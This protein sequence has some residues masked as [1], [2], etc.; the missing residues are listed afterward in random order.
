MGG[1]GGSSTGGAG[2]SYYHNGDGYG[3]AGGT[4]SAGG[5]SLGGGGGGAGYSS[6]PGAGGAAVGGIFNSGTLHLVGGA[7]SGNIAVGGGG[8]GGYFSTFGG[9]GGAAVGG[10]LNTGVLTLDNAS[11][12]GNAA[13]GGA[14]G[15]GQFGLGAAG[16]ATSNL[17]GAAT[18][19]NQPHTGSV[20]LSGA[21]TQGQTLTAA[22]TLADGNGLGTIG[23]Q[24]KSDGANI[25]GAVSSTL[26]LAQAQ[27]GHLITVTG[28]Y[29]DGAGFA[30]SATSA[31]TSAVANVNDAPTGAVTITG[32]ATQGQT[33]TAANTLADADGLGTIGYQ[34][35]ADG[36]NISGATGSTLAL[37]QAQVGHVITV[38]AGYTDG[39]G[40]AESVT[41]SGTSAVANVNDAPTG[42]VTIAG[43]A[44]QGQVL[45]ASNTL[46]DADGL[47]T[48]GYQWKAD[49]ANI[50]GATGSTLTLAQAQ[51]GHMITVA[52]SYVDSL[53]TAESVASSGTTAVANVNDA[54]TG[55]VSIAGTATQGQV[56]TASNTL[57]DADG[58]G[59]IGYQWKAD[60][61]DISGATTSTLTLAQAQVGHVITVAAGYTDGLGAAESVASTG[62]AAVTNANDAPTGSV[63]IAG[64]ATQGQTLTA[65]NTLADA[66][67]LGTI[68]YQWKSDGANISGAT[69]S[70]L[71]LAQAQVGHVITVSAGYTDGQGTAESVASSGTTAV[72]NVN[73]AP[74]GLPTVSGSAVAGATLTAHVDAIADPDGLGVFSYAWKADGAPIGGATGA[75]LTLGQAQVGHLITVTA[76]Y[77]DGGATAESLTSAPSATVTSPPPPPPPPPVPSPSVTTSATVDGAVV[78]TV[79]TTAPDGSQTHTVAVAPLPA[80]HA[81]SIGDSATADIPLVS[82]GD[83]HLLAVGVPTGTGFGASGP[84]A[85]ETAGSA[86]P[87]L[88]GAIDATSSAADQQQMDAGAGAFLRLHPAAPVVVQTIALT[89]SH[90]DTP[91]AVTGLAGSG[92]TTALVID[93]HN[94]PGQTQL[95]L[96]NVDF[97]AIIGPA[98]VTGGAGSQTVYADSA[99]QYLVLG[100]GDDVLHGGGGDD[101]LGSAG[102]DD[103]IFGDDG[104]DNV[105]GGIGDDVVNGGA[106]N[107]VVQG[108][109]GDDLVQGNAG[110]DLVYGG[111][112]NDAVYGGQGDDQLWGDLGNDRVFGNLGAD[113]LEGGDGDDAVQGNQGDD[114]VR[115]GAGN[116][117]AYGGQGNDTV[118]GGQGDDQLW[119]D[120]GDDVLTGGP[121]ADTLTGG[122]GA[123]TFVYAR[124]DGADRITDFHQGEGDRI[125]LSG[126]HDAYT[127]TQVGAD[128]VVDFGHG[129]SLVLANVQ[130]SSLASGWIVG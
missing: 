106:G 44:A 4:A 47:G 34:W 53:A 109:Q 69:G 5:L 56:L 126:P 75:A 3:G 67:G 49:G 59:T 105:F 77:V 116:D 16:A 58:L 99:P 128:T 22:N 39:Q 40:T 60:G 72:A 83:V 9:A 74:T 113:T 118:D 37:A 90:T 82:L 127:V 71:A 89:G 2:G 104:D 23:Y 50:S 8:G 27:V 115:G 124:G 70:T 76:S 51:V 91:F 98:H 20:S 33:L 46:A 101:T 15:D 6:T 93:T 10:V 80:G 55:S 119:G 125:Q 65:S 13:G 36:T 18:L 14:A 11:I 26:T 120:L 103:A 32:A 87:A 107:D 21:A 84:V 123:D 64:T 63:A 57:A 61:T 92:A 129:E 117:M 41:S 12:S 24:W 121:G 29:T 31:A 7:V 95:T 111:Q 110:N 62:T 85:P 130:L 102:G 52:A 66:D 35:K 97:A 42:S 25:A 19:V 45:T 114:V 28:S 94:L 86:L 73:D 96:D 122:A 17:S 1:D 54:P 43:T 78:T 48:I 108:N 38:S 100:A 79:T 68:G 30:E 88:V 81:D 112:G